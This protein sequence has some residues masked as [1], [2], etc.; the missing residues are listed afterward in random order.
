MADNSKND[1]FPTIRLDEEDRRE[2]QQ[3]RQPEKQKGTVPPASSAKTSSTTSNSSG[4]NGLW[5]LLVALVALAGCGGCYYL[6]TLME[7]QKAQ[8]NAAEA[9]IAQLEKRLSATGEEIG[10]STVALQVKVTELSN[11]TTELWE[12]MDKLWASAWRR[13]QKEIADLGD[14]VGSVK[15]SLDKQI[16]GVDKDVKAQNSEIGS[17]KTQL[18]SVADEILALNVQMEQAAGDKRSYQQQVKNLNDKLSVL[19]TRNS[20]LSGRIAGLENEI[21]EI[22]TKVVSQGNGGGGGAAPA[23]EVMVNP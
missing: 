6:Y 18:A 2:Y 14:R 22:A 19:E 23:T 11:K 9:R 5:V 13:N 20:S 1:D 16:D 17:L 21:R 8:A 3:K 15:S 10:E 7:Q 4:G 12:Q